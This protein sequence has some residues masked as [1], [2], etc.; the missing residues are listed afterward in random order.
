MD[1]LNNPSIIIHRPLFI[2]F[3]QF[4]FFSKTS[5]YLKKRLLGS[6]TYAPLKCNILERSAKGWIQGGLNSLRTGLF[7]YFN[8]LVNVTAGGPE[9][10]RGHM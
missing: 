2:I 9:S 7:L 10:P 6:S 4:P 1:Q 5:A 3:I 8:Y